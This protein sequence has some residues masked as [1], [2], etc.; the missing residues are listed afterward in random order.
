MATMDI[1]FSEGFMYIFIIFL[2]PGMKG[3]G[4]NISL[5][6]QDQ[7][8][9]YQ[10]SLITVKNSI[11]AI[12]ADIPEEQDAKFILECTLR[13]KEPSFSLI[14]NGL[15]FDQTCEIRGN[16]NSK[17]TQNTCHSK[18]L[19]FCHQ[20][21]PFPPNTRTN[22]TWSILLKAD[23]SVKRT[24]RLIGWDE[25]NINIACDQNGS[26]QLEICHDRYSSSY[27]IPKKTGYSSFILVGIVC[28]YLN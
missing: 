20:E 3:E 16:A 5:D 15:T 10:S 1:N 14:K 24:M 23:C 28:L 11:N 27:P 17:E 25:F 6:S 8:L 19:R 18:E 12:G 2:A 4:V 13:R 26:S 9:S 22:L 7:V 21:Y